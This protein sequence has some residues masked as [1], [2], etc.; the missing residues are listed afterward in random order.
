MKTNLFVQMLCETNTHQKYFA[1]TKFYVMYIK[2]LT[3]GYL[4]YMSEK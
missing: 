4:V 1:V 2:S 3:D